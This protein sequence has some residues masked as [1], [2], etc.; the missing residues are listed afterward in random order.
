MQSS[1]PLVEIIKIVPD[2]VGLADGMAIDWMNES[3]YWA[4]PET[5]K[6]E[7]FDLGGNET[8][9]IVDTGLDKPRGVAVDP[10]EGYDIL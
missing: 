10:F 3:L 7:M 1:G 4:N 8:R 9:T 2:P 5:R 6:I